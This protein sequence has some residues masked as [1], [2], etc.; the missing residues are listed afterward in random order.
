VNTLIVSGGQ[1]NSRNTLGGAVA[2]RVKTALGSHG[3]NMRSHDLYGDGFSP[4]PES[5]ELTRKFTFDEQVLS[6]QNDV[7]WADVLVF[8]YPDWWGF[9]P[10]ILKGWVDRIFS[11]GFAYDYA[12]PEFEKKELVRMLGDKKSVVICTADNDKPSLLHGLFW[13][14]MVARQTGRENIYLSVYSGIRNKSEAET[15]EFLDRTENELK[16]ILR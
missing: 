1:N 6:Y 12:G 15:A 9:C 5:A 3:N 2:E 4:V 13:K 11:A 10:A 14:D 8:V 16:S 7:T